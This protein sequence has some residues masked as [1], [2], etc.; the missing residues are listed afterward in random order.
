MKNQ[1]NVRRILITQETSEQGRKL[2]RRLE[3][4]YGA[5]FLYHSFLRIKPLSLEEFKKSDINILDFTGIIFSNK[6]SMELFFELLK[7]LGIELPLTMRYFC[8]TERLALYLQKF[9]SIRKRRW[10]YPKKGK[11]KEE[12][13][14]YLD[15]YKD[16]K[17]LFV[18]RPKGRHYILTHLRKHKRYFKILPIYE[19]EAEA[20][21][22]VEKLRSV[23]LICFSALAAREVYCELYPDECKEKPVGVYGPEAKKVVKRKKMRVGFEGP[24]EEH[25]TLYDLINAYLGE[26]KKKK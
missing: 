11:G 6:V 4:K 16:E 14:K 22:D 8:P 7:K 21:P 12:L 24:T 20:F 10:H 5:E 23:E 1:E 9:V 18:G 3:K 17:F 2:F 19:F 25:R 15:K 26:E 13:L